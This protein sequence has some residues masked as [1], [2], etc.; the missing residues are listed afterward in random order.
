MKYNKKKKCFNRTIQQSGRQ[1]PGQHQA[2][3]LLLPGEAQ[4]GEISEERSCLSTHPGQALAVSL[5][6]LLPQLD[7]PETYENSTLFQDKL[8]LCPS[9]ESSVKQAMP[10][11]R[12]VFQAAGICVPS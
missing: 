9:K 4:R 7:L 6:L 8:A 1:C 3:S 5:S 11:L 10:R 12:S 2:S